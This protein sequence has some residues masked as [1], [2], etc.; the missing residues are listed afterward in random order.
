MNTTSDPGSI[1]G[2][3]TSQSPQS[4]EVAGFFYVLTSVNTRALTPQYGRA[5]QTEAAHDT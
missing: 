1:P 3:S 4:F 5:P 2:I